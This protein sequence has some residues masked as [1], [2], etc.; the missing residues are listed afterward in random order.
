MLLKYILHHV[1]AFGVKV[2]RRIMIPF[3]KPT[4]V[5]E[6]LCEAID[7]WRIEHPELTV[8]EI[9]KALEKIR[10][11]LTESLIKHD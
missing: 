9:L 8:L 10:V 2:H 7:D 11:K 6:G 1:H 4:D 5:C 3:R